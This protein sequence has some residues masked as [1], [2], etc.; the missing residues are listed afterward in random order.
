LKLKKVILK[1]KKV[2]LK[3]KKVIFNHFGNSQCIYI[4]RNYIGSS[5]PKLEIMILYVRNRR[6]NN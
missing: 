6:K 5:I 2:I 1:L 4:D 3:L